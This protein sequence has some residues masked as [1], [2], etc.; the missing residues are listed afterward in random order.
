VDAILITAHPDVEAPDNVEVMTKPV[1]LDQF[2]GQVRR[3]LAAATSSRSEPSMA[4]VTSPSDYKVEL[5]LYIS[6]A[7][8]ASIQACRN[9]ERLLDGFDRAQVKFSICDLGRDP[10]AGEADRIAFTPTLVKRFPEPRMWVLGNLREPEI[11]VD[12]LRACGV[13]G[14]Q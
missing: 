3:V 11:L 5:V 12:L 10:L 9:L 7:S 14:V 2:L 13:D 6:P 4:N 1:E 8:P